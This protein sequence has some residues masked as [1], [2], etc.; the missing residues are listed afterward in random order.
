MGVI[1][2]QQLTHYYDI[3]R[4]VEIT[5]SKEI[6]RMLNMD[7]RQVYVKC[8]GAQWPCIINSTSYMASKII[9]GT[10]GAAFE[11]LSKKEPVQVNI[12]YAYFQEQNQL[13]TFLVTGKVTNIQPYGNTNELVIVTISFTQR[14]PDALIELTGRLL[15]TNDNAVK[16]R[17]ERIVLNEDSKRKLTITKE[18][19]RI[20][21][22]GVSRNCILRDLSF[23]GAKIMLMGLQKF[24]ENRDAVLEI[25]FEDPP[26]TVL[27]RGKIVEALPIDGRKDIVSASIRF[28]EGAIPLSYKIH[29]NDFL[30]ATKKRQLNAQDQITMQ[31]NMASGAFE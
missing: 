26:E 22:Q 17:E 25:F 5:F 16:R 9:V 27:I 24:I 8:N 21:I 20:A 3:Y 30:S 28:D 10:R 2:S 1:T 29:I 15:E 7:P 4:D 13:S 19:T 23:S 18:E 11:Q 31:R 6:I 14:P 12:R